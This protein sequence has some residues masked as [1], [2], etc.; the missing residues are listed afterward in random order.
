MLA[1][2]QRIN[3]GRC[4][5]GLMIEL[6]GGGHG[7]GRGRDGGRSRCGGHEAAGR[8]A[9]LMMMAE[10]VIYHWIGGCRRDVPGEAG[11]VTARFVAGGRSIDGCGRS[12]RRARGR[13]RAESRH[14][15]GRGAERGRRDRLLL[16]M[17]MMGSCRRHVRVHAGGC[18]RRR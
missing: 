2:R 9:V 15:A 13:G 1:G 4:G 8:S 12:Q 5:G 14:H 18:A 7:G 17:M 11:R 16:L 6:C 3:D 10:G